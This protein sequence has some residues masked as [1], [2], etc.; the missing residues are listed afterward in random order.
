MFCSLL[1]PIFVAFMLISSYYVL[2]A[3]VARYYGLGDFS[4][5]V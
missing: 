1:V 5:Y 3:G 2:I 4:L